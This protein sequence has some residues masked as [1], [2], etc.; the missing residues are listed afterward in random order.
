MTY[1]P[2]E[3]P[4]TV[5]H[6]LNANGSVY[7]EVWNV[8]S[9]VT[10]ANEGYRVVAVAKDGRISKA[11]AQRIYDQELRNHNDCFGK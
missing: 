3:T 6:V 4:T 2:A 7:D 11:R 9:G 1:A 8:D 5:A 10:Y